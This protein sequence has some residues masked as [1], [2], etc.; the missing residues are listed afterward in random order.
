MSRKTLL[1]IF[2]LLACSAPSAYAQT[3]ECSDGATSYSANFRGTCS[4]HGG[5]DVWNDNEMKD[6]ANQWCDDKPSLCENSHWDGIEGHGNHPAVTDEDED[7]D[8]DDQ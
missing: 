8:G 1:L 2:G 7:D 4:H 3:A 6:E 5:V